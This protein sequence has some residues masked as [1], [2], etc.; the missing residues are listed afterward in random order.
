MRI[1]RPNSK[2]SALVITML[3][4]IG[5]GFMGM[6]TQ[7]F[8]GVL[9][10]ADPTSRR[11]VVS[12]EQ[13]RLWLIQGADT[14]FTA[15]V[16]IGSGE[17]F[18]FN[19]KKYHFETPRG[20]RTILAKKDDPNWTPPDWHY[21][22]K[23]AARGLEPVPMKRGEK[24]TLDDGTYLEI[25]GD[26]VGR[27]NQFGNFYAWTPGM[28]IIF[29]GKIFIPPFDTRQRMVPNALGPHKLVLG[30]GYLIHG[31]NPYDENSI[32][33]AASHG[34]IRMHNDDLTYLYSIVEAGTP[35][36]II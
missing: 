18:V 32:G 10:R 9:H 6:Q 23:A 4:V 17:T 2:Q 26:D 3:T 1:K 31:V 20:R 28:E 8:N 27:V 24:Y 21:Y 35:V 25:R 13:K 36:D 15:P 5:L 16:A 11:I 30:E 22:E 33:T 12:L 7:P 19:G 29:D 14:L 34:C